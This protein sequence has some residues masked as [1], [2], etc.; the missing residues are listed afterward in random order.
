MSEK[1]TFMIRQSND[2]DTL[3][4][5]VEGVEV[6]VDSAGNLMVIDGH[7][8]AMFASGHWVS[9]HPVDPMI[10]SIDPTP[11]ID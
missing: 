3:V 5:M 8:V 9:A 4:F 2:P 10:D 1:S 11:Q 6:D 7:C